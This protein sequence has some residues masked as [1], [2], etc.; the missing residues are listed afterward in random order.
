MIIQNG[1]FFAPSVSFSS[2][3]W[4]NNTW[5]LLRMVLARGDEV[6]SLKD[7][8]IQPSEKISL[9][10]VPAGKEGDLQQAAEID[11]PL[12]HLLRRH[13]KP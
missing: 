8:P 2:P 9:A 10:D 6:Q 3:T 1:L 7:A 13:S 5:K 4:V 11:L 12:G